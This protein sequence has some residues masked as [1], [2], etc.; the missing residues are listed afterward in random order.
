MLPR[1][2]DELRSECRHG[3]VAEWFR[4][5]SARPSTQVLFLPPP[6]LSQLASAFGHGVDRR[7]EIGVGVRE[8]REQRLVAA[9]REEYVAVEQPVEQARVAPVVG[10][11]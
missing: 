5:R 2:P 1:E 10:A 9:R 6:L 4:R 7:V 3:G 8:A 11:P